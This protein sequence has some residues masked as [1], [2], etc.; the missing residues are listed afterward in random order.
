[1]EVPLLSAEEHE[2]SFSFVR[3]AAE[4]Q[5]EREPVLDIA[6]IDMSGGA[7]AADDGAPE[8]AGVVREDDAEDRPSA[9]RRRRGPGRRQARQAP[10]GSLEE[11]L[12][13]LSATL[14]ALAREVKEQ[15]GE[16]RELRR[17]LEGVSRRLA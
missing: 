3:P 8:V 9:P 2:G 17:G 16:V 10:G 4:R 14:G 13:D 12:V 1:V 7:V 11:A 15:A 5:E 6:A